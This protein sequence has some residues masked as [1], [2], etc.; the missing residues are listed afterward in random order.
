MK[1]CKTIDEL[2]KYFIAKSRSSASGRHEFELLLND[3]IYEAYWLGDKDGTREEKRKHKFDQAEI[4][5][6]E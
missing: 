6:E 2:K 4:T 1:K 5:M 3:A